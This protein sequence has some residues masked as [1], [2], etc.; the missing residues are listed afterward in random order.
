MKKKKKLG[1]ITVFIASCVL[2]AL[3]AT[4]GCILMATSYMKSTTESE[5]EACLMSTGNAVLGTFNEIDPGVYR[6]SGNVLYKGETNLSDHLEIVDSLKQKTD[7]ECTFFYGDTRFLTTI[8]DE[9]GS[10]VI[11]T[12][13]SDEVKKQVL[14]GG[15]TYFAKNIDIAGRDYYGYYIP[16]EQDGKVMG[17]LFTG[18][19]SSALTEAVNG[20]LLYICFVG[21]IIMII[22]AIDS[23]LVGRMIASRISTLRDDMVKLSE[24]HLD[25]QISNDNHISELEEL[26]MAAEKLR[27]QLVD[28]VQMILSCANTVDTSVAQVD[29]S[30]D[31]CTSAVKDLSTTMEEM[32]YGAQ[33][34]AG[35]VEKVATDMDEISNNIADIANS[36]Q[37]TKDVT[38]TVANVSSTAKKNLQELLDANSYTTKSADDVIASISSVSE[39][40]QQITTAAKMIMDIS[41]QTNLL[42]LNASIEAARAGEAGRG[43]AVVASEIQSLAEQSNSSA[44]QIHSIIEEI[45]SK[46][47]ECTKIAGEI[48]EAVGKEASA[49]NDVSSSFDDVA[50][51]VS[52]AAYAVGKIAD[53]VATVEKNK[54]SILDSVSDLSGISEENAASAQETN[55]STEEVRANI[56]EV[57]H[58]AAELK[59]VIEQLNNSVAF[60]KL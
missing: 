8:K 45:T 36:A 9:S 46:T 10:R 21:L 30:L 24:G 27:T 32:A 50:S 12:K 37:A 16:V 53:N 11:L 56:E 35:S 23:V 4:A 5:I 57:A 54:I 60:F 58:Q 19:P 17:M 2:P 44:Q 39:A 29:S 31:N 1:M 15:N 47:A 18:K 14:E 42:S 40:V 6:L 25:S 41:D 7:I 59:A 55:A 52:D 48:H 26:A 33:S 38:E 13:C 49:L 34:M 20:F 51:N 22:S 28:V 3:L 43:F